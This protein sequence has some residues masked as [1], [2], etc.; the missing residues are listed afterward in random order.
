M[1]MWDLAKVGA[2]APIRSCDGHES[3]LENVFEP[4][5]QQSSTILETSPKPLAALFS[6]YRAKAD[7]LRL[8]IPGH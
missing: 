5:P 2:A 8:D 4:A 6:R 1:T 3:R 7:R